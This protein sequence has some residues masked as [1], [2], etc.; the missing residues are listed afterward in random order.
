MSDDF[1][2]DTHCVVC[3]EPRSTH[4]TES[5]NPRPLFQEGRACRDCDAYITAA[6]M[7][8]WGIKDDNARAFV[9]RTLHDFLNFVASIKKAKRVADEM[10]Q[11]EMTRLEAEETARNEAGCPDC[12]YI[13]DD[14]ATHY[15]NCVHFD[16]DLIADDTEEDWS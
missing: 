13:E 5:N 11:T 15:E 10:M 3:K 7:K 9:L 6:R 2:L 8:T 16:T 4:P 14:V 12:G 1:D